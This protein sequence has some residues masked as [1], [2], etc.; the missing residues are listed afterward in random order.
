MSS[1]GVRVKL[2]IIPNAPRNQVLGWRGDALSVKVSA[3]PAQGK[4]NRELCRFLADVLGVRAADI[5]IL[6]GE[7]SRNKTV[8]IAGISAAQARDRLKQATA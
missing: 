1:S 2:K 3:V 6:E 5:T 7:T 4:A 8:H